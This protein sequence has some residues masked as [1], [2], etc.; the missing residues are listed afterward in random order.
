MSKDDPDLSHIRTED[1]QHVYE[2]C[3]DSFLMMDALKLDLVFMRSRLSA[4]PLCLEIGIGSGIVS[5]YLSRLLAGR[6]FF[7]ATDK[8]PKAAAVARQTFARN[9]V[10]GDVVLTDLVAGLEHRLSKRV[11]SARRASSR[12][13]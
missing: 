2:P 13:R 3:E 7:L 9:R 1:F 4:A 5:S 10:R 12:V 8:N 6:G 11:V